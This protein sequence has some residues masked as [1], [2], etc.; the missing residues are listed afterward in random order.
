MNYEEE[1]RK[2][3]DK[4]EERSK[5]WKK[6]STI[7]FYIIATPIFSYLM[8]LYTV[9]SSSYVATYLID[10]FIRPF[11]NIPN[12]TIWQLAGVVLTIQFV[13]RDV[14][15]SDNLK[16]EL[17]HEKNAYIKIFIFFFFPWIGL[18]TAWLVKNQ[19]FLS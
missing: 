16:K 8:L 6:V 11:Y 19:F 14:R 2:L 17:L 15:N 13:F 10:W 4:I 9:W 5:M 1:T 3:L 18:V 12:F 7:I